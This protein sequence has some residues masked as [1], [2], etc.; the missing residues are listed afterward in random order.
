MTTSV[1]DTAMKPFALSASLLLL[2]L[3]GCAVYPTYDD[4][5]P[6][7][8]PAYGYAPAYVP[9]PVYVRP[10]PMFY[11]GVYYHRDYRGGYRHW[12]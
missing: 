4:L 8:A 10:A 9:P 5:G 11:G 2:A 7:P 6:Y 1:S 12:H 3:T